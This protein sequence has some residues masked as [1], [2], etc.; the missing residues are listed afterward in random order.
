MSRAVPGHQGHTASRD[1]LERLV[2]PPRRPRLVL[3]RRT[4]EGLEVARR[5]PRPF[6]RVLRRQARGLE[7]GARRGDIVPGTRVQRTERPIRLWLVGLHQHRLAQRRLCLGQLGIDGA[8]GLGDQPFVLAAHRR[9]AGCVVV[10][11]HRC[12]VAAPL[13]RLLC[14]SAASTVDGRWKN[15]CSGRR[16]RARCC[17]SSA[18]TRRQQAA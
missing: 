18:N 11:L 12:T 7:V 13:A 14:G 3:A 9:L 6:G 5:R 10:P 2:V 1:I 8:D 4:A 16:A 15:L 17:S